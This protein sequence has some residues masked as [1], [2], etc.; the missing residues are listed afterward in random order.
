[1]SN[2]KP[3]DYTELCTECMTEMC[4]IEGVCDVCKEKNVENDDNL[5]D[6]G[7]QHKETCDLIEAYA[8]DIVRGDWIDLN[9]TL[10]LK[11]A[12]KL[13]VLPFHADTVFGGDMAK[14]VNVSFRP[15]SMTRLRLEFR[16]ETFNL[17]YHDDTLLLIQE[18]E[19]DKIKSATGR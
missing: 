3:T 15:N 14:V 9:N 16:G 5:L 18:T 17:T 11:V 10:N 7:T 2:F 4:G 6:V 1:M 13:Q 19:K 8:N 12:N